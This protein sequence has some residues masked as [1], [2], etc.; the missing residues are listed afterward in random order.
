VSGRTAPFKGFSRGVPIVGQRKEPQGP[1]PGRHFYHVAFAEQRDGEMP[2]FRSTEVSIP[3]V[4]YEMGQLRAIE[5]FIADEIAKD[6]PDKARPDVAIVSYK[7]LRFMTDEVL[8]AIERER[9]SAV[10]LG[11]VPAVEGE[12]LAEGGGEA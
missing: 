3:E 12:P 11:G 7:S 2:R 5:G 1:P 8:E 9:Q 10:E 6:K 4:I